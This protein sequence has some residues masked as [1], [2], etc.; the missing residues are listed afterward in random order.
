MEKSF[1]DFEL[2]VEK[3]AE[4]LWEDFE[5]TGSVETYLKYLQKAHKNEEPEPANL[6]Y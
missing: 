6:P 3:N 1:N 4:T 5:K 2:T